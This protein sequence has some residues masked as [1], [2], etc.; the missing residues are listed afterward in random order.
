MENN[1]RNNYYIRMRIILYRKKKGM[2]QNDVAD[3]IG[4][5]RSTYSYYENKATKYTPEFLKSV[6]KALGVSPNVFDLNAILDDET[7]VIPRLE[8]EFSE[9]PE[10]F[11]A[12]GNEQKLINLYRILSNEGKINTYNFMLDELKKDAQIE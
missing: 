7:V 8:N 3:A 2:T 11:S 4:M 10:P 1:E 5:K 12:T 9:V 6:A